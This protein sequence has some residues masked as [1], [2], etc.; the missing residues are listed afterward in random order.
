MWLRAVIRQNRHNIKHEAF[1]SD[2]NV[3]LKPGSK[4]TLDSLI[5]VRKGKYFFPALVVGMGW[6]GDE[7]VLNVL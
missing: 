1:I 5:E 3:Y 4:V 7:F 6:E 2:Q